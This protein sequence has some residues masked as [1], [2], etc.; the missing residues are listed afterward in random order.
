LRPLCELGE[1]PDPDASSIVANGIQSFLKQVPNKSS[2]PIESVVQ[3]IQPLARYQKLLH[4][5]LELEQEREDYLSEL[6]PDDDFSSCLS[7]FL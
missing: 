4:G 3:R 1:G 7:E 2:V 5:H 6:L